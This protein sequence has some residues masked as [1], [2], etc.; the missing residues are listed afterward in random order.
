MLKGLSLTLQEAARGCGS[1]PDKINH[2]VKNLDDSEPIHGPLTFG[3][4]RYIINPSRSEGICA[5]DPALVASMSQGTLESTQNKLI[6]C[7]NFS[8]N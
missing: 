7:I 4:K 2:F 1:P 6:M 3:S 5:T 8:N